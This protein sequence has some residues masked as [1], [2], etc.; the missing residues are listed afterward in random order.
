L[1]IERLFADS[2]SRDVQPTEEGGGKRHA[3]G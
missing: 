2:V 1:S 3:Q